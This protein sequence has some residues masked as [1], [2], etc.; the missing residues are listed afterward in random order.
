MSDKNKRQFESN[1]IGLPPLKMV[2][3]SVPEP[4]PGEG[5][6]PF[7]EFASEKPEEARST[8]AKLI[9]HLQ[10]PKK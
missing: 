5:R 10:E 1:V 9:G 2:L 8:L 3:G 7:R 6:R 4:D